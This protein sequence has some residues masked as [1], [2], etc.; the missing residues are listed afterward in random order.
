MENYLDI[1]ENSLRKKESVLDHIQE[2]NEKQL[3]LFDNGEM[4]LEAYDAYVDEKSECIDE[5]N[6][7]DEG[8]EALYKGIAKELEGNR[9]KYRDHIQRLQVLIKS[10]TDKSVSIQAMEARN[11]KRV[12]EYFKRERRNMQTAR[13]TSQAALNYYQSMNN[14]KNVE[15]QF[16]DKKK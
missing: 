11:K 7:L 5:L 16:L 13:K 1:L 2:V 3:A 8:F 10:V 14:S 9:I 12:E 6:R 15:A 4:S